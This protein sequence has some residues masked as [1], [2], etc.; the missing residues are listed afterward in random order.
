MNRDKLIQDLLVA[1]KV[2]T[3]AIP[4][5]T[6]MRATLASYST[7]LLARLHHGATTAIIPEMTLDYL[8]ANEGK[9]EEWINLYHHVVE[10]SYSEEGKTCCSPRA[11]VNSLSLYPAMSDDPATYYR[12]ATAL[13]STVTEIQDALMTEHP[14]VTKRLVNSEAE[15]RILSYA[16]SDDNGRTRLVRLANDHLVNLILDHPDKWEEITNVIIQRLTDDVDI[17]SSII[18]SQHS[19]PLSAGTL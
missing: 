11:A 5:E 17:I 7:A 10:T 9:S 8:F 18:D 19:R 12:Q 15:R 6:L 3:H 1:I 2:S 16:D 13:T 14:E 4:N